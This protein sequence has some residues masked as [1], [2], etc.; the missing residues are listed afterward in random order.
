[1][2]IENHKLKLCKLIYYTIKKLIYMIHTIIEV[3]VTG[4]CSNR[5]SI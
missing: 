1:M 5:Y 4:K 3:F 2:V